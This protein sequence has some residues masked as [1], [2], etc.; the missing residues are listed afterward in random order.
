[1]LLRYI[2][3]FKN[4]VAMHPSLQELVSDLRSWTDTWI[5]AISCSPPSFDD[6]ILNVP[7][8]ARHFV[9]ERL[10]ELVNRVVA[11]VDRKHRDNERSKQPARPVVSLTSSS[12]E[13]ILAAL[14]NSYEGPGSIRP[15]GPRHDNDFV[16]IADIQIAPTDGELKSTQQP[17]L[18]ANMYG[19]PHPLP[20]E[21]MEQL[22]DIQFRLLREELT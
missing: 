16:D 12:N 18:P 2:T 17:F 21:T 14:H 9:V 4:A 13:G 8:Q 10:R 15:G 20:S 1:M 5:N 7:V 3:R 11:I 22:L 19:A 6:S